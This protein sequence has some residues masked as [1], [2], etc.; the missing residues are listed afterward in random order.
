VNLK[1][2]SQLPLSFGQTELFSFEH[3]VAGGNAEIIKRLLFC[4]AGSEPETLFLWGRPGAGKSHLLQA[5]CTASAENERASVYLPLAENRKFT[6]Q[7]LE[8]LEALSIV[9]LDDVDRIAGD[10]YWEHAV[11]NL[12]NRVREEHHTL[13]LS[14]RAAP[15][16]IRFSL[17]DLAS[18]MNWGLIYQ[19]Q[20]LD[21][22]GKLEVLQ[23]KARARRFELPE[24]VGNYLIRRLPRDMHALCQFLDRLDQASLVAKRKLTIPFV[25][26]IM[27]Q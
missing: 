16:S 17:A 23:Q 18:R 12:F 2:P 24:E 20:D 13:V 9:C 6:P 14:A 11:F 1:Q 10:E 8:G 25:K 7:L 5:L 21:D 27:T 3:F 4:A 15:K 26:E 19:L 22:A